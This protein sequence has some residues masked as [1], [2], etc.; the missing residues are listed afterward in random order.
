MKKLN[1]WK[2]SLIS[3][4]LSCLLIVFIIIN[5][6]DDPD[7]AGARFAYNFTFFFP[8]LLLIIVSAVVGLVFTFKYFRNEYK[9]DGKY[10]I[11]KLIVPLILMS[12]AILQIIVFVFKTVFI[13]ILSFFYTVAY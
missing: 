10:R 11:F 4:M 7:F 6:I 13:L 9:D 8:V 2:V 1:N 5:P 12:P 3:S